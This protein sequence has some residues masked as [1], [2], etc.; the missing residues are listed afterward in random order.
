MIE[1]A[2]KHVP[3]NDI[4][5]EPWRNAQL[6]PNATLQQAIRNL[7]QTA[8]Q[9][10]LVVS[11]DGTLFG[12]LT[13]GD[14]RRGLLRGLDLNRPL[15]AI[16]YREPL[17]VPPQLGRDMVLQLM[18]LNKIHQLPIVDEDRPV[19]GLHLWNELIVPGQRPNLMVIMAGG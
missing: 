15:E 12:T 2:S 19:V 11:P 17:V 18:R 4:P 13:D 16:T 9:I 7:D 5:T 6:P 3:E 8:L 14:I 10:V 1:S